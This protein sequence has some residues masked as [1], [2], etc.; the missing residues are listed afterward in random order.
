MGT[1]GL[2]R[3]WLLGHFRLAVGS[4]FVGEAEW[5]LRKAKSLLK[6]LALTP[7]HR[8]HREQA[9]DLLWPQLDPETAG[10]NLHQTIYIAR[11]LLDPAGSRGTSYLHL[12][13]EILTLSPDEPPWIDVEAFET[14]VAQA[15]ASQDPAAYQAALEAGQFA[16]ER[17][18]WL[19]A[20][21]IRRRDLIANIMCNFEVEL[22]PRAELEFAEE[23]QGLAALERNRLVERHGTRIVVT[24]LGQLFVRNVAMVFDS[25]LHRGGERRFSRTV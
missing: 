11:R 15:R 16:T 25:Y 23:L 13:G 3:A 24:P 14:A 1:G 10:H 8:L 7:G 2:L 21:D 4:R 17:G 6:L 18:I 5:R 9:I 20:D 19:S 12:R 22:G